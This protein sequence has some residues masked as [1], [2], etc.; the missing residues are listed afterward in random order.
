MSKH[1][2]NCGQ[3]VDEKYCSYCG[4]SISVER[5]DLH[6][7]MH[8]FIHGVLH[9]DKGYFYTIKELTLRPGETLR[10]YIS[11]HRV[12][13]FSPLGY[14]IISTTIFLFLAHF[15]HVAIMPD[16]DGYGIT[17]NMQQ[18]NTMLGLKDVNIW[19]EE[20]YTFIL[21][22]LL[23]INALMTFLVFRKDGYNYGENL[24]LN[25][26][27]AGHQ[28]IMCILLLPINYYFNNNV[29]YSLLQIIPQ[30]LIAIYFYIT[31]F[32]SY[33]VWKRILKSLLCIILAFFVVIVISTIAFMIYFIIVL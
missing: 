23:P 28:I 33:P 10:N 19:V 2:K 1:C 9:V 3:K 12:K 21:L 17:E 26:Y 13:Y 20:H 15:F 18:D 31:F 4:Q 27:V 6:H 5:I 11:G 14:I 25:A 32:D 8:D 30:Y 7:L 22:A 24:V 16:Y 29:V